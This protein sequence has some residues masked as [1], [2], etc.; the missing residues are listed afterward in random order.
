M[1]SRRAR[2][3][4]L[5][6]AWG[7][8]ERRVRVQRALA[9]LPPDQHAVVNLSFVDGLSHAEIAG[10]LGSPLGTVKSRLRLSYLKIRDMVEDLN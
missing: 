4:T 6:E 1:I 9:E 3:A 2:D 5:D 8:E 7:Q 10:R